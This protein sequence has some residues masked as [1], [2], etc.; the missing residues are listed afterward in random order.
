MTRKKKII[1]IATGLG[2]ILLA[3]L[4]T[5]FAIG[6]L[7]DNDVVQPSEKPSA[8]ASRKKM[9]AGYKFEDAGKT[10]E[11]L[12]YYKEAKELCEK[13]DTQCNVSVEMKIKMMQKT[14]E[15]EAKNPSEAEGEKAKNNR[16]QTNSSASSKFAL[17]KDGIIRLMFKWKKPAN[18]LDIDVRFLLA[19][20]RTLLAWVRTGLT[21]IA[22]GV[23]IA[24][25]ST[26]SGYGTI[27]GVGAIGFGG[28]LAMIGYARYHAADAAIRA[29]KLPAQGVGSIFVVAGVVVFAVF[30][31]IARELRL[32]QKKKK[33]L[34]IN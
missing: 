32:F 17:S 14:L 10:E 5:V 8:E 28:I 27:A 16:Q 3:G 9:Q 19:N 12:K 2:I 18:E 25:I 20:E 7:T 13:N 26:D 4:T 34:A 22:G 24:F 31:I 33:P 23:A 6:T 1:L 21:L 30:L 11:A 15:F 29:G